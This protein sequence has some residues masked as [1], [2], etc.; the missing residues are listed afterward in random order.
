[1]HNTLNKTSVMSNGPPCIL[2]VM[3]LYQKLLASGLESLQET[4]GGGSII[5]WIFES[6]FHSIPG[7]TKIKCT[8][9]MRSNLENLSTVHVSRLAS[10]IDC[11][12]GMIFP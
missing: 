6:I 9:R 5:F 2:Y 4:G 1:M 7:Q 8:S 11:E 3:K 10:L 12:V